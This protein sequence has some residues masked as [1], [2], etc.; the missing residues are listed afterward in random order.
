[1]QARFARIERLVS[2]GGV[3]RQVPAAL[4]SGTGSA[5]GPHFE[6]LAGSLGMALFEPGAVTLDGPGD[7]LI[8][9]LPGLPEP[10]PLPGGFGFR[11]EGGDWLRLGAVIDGSPAA[12][13]GLQAGEAVQAIDGRDAR[14]WSPAQ[15]W[16]ALAGREQVALQL[17]RDGRSRRVELRRERFFPLLR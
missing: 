3:A 17:F 9:E 1:V 6:R 7:R 15:A 16:Q 5:R 14:A 4:E 8:V 10:P 2:P 12:A 13:A 11:L